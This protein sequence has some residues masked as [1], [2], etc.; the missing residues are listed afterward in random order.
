MIYNVTADV[1]TKRCFTVK[2][3]DANEAKAFVSAY[4]Y[5]APDRYPM[6]DVDVKPTGESVQSVALPECHAS[7]FEN[8]KDPDDE[9]EPEEYFSD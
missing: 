8:R 7:F 2:A 6:F 3:T 4:L 1:T 9:Y 5:T